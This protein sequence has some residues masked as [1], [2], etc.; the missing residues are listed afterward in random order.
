[1]VA[2]VRERDGFRSDGGRRAWRLPRRFPPTSPNL[3]AGECTIAFGL[4]GPSLSVGAGPAAPIEALLVAHDLLAAGD[5]P[6]LVVIGV[7]DVGATVRALWQ[8]AGWPEP[9]PGAAAV[10]LRAGEGQ[11]LERQPLASRHAEA[12]K[13]GG[14]LGTAEPGW[15]ALLAAVRT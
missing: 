4:Y 7:D 1:M 12:E 14:K 11:R 6:A 8:A 3:C 10:L 13:A 15:P 2:A 9:E 5:A